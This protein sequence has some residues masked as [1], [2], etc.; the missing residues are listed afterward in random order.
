M[1]LFFSTL[2]GLTLF[3]S[4][5]A[6]DSLVTIKPSTARYYLEVEDEVFILRE[7]DSIS[8]ELIFNQALMLEIKDKIIS[9]YKT[10]SV[11]YQNR[12]KALTQHIE[13]IREQLDDY[14]KE[15]RKQKILKWLAIGLG[16]VGAVLL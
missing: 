1:K 8:N 12:E 14:D 5:Y 6:Q 4:T 3:F 9:S 11:S 2:C 15:V 10:D 13:L 16:V 7:K